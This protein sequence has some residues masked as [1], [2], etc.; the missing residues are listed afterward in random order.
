MTRNRIKQVVWVVV[1]LLLWLFFKDGGLYDHIKAQNARNRADFADTF[2]DDKAAALVAEKTDCAC[3]GG[4][5]VGPGGGRYCL[6][7]GGKKRYLKS[8]K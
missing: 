6:D 5:C 7:E 3:P 4:V 2:S 8:D 1:I